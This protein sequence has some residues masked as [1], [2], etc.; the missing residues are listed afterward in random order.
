M[1]AI[2][3]DSG[4]PPKNSKLLKRDFVVD[5]S[6]FVA[7]AS[8]RSESGFEL[9]G[10]CDPERKFQFPYSCTC[11][12]NGRGSDQIC[13]AKAELSVTARNTVH[14]SLRV[15]WP[16]NQT[17]APLGDVLFFPDG[18]KSPESKRVVGKCFIREDGRIQIVPGDDEQRGFPFKVFLVLGHEMKRAIAGDVVADLR[19]LYP[20]PPPP[21]YGT[22]EKVESELYSSPSLDKLLRNEF[23]DRKEYFRDN[24]P[25]PI[26][27]H[28]QIEMFSTTPVHDIDNYYDKGLM[29]Q[30]ET[31]SLSLSSSNV[32]EEPFSVGNTALHDLYDF[33]PHT[34]P[35]MESTGNCWDFTTSTQSTTPNVNDVELS[36]PFDD[37]LNL[38]A[39]P[40]L[41]LDNVSFLLRCYLAVVVVSYHSQLLSVLIT[42]PLLPSSS[43]ISL[44]IF[45]VFRLYLSSPLYSLDL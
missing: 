35:F 8:K 36:F 21:Q 13:A 15:K 41:D 32:F 17:N 11:T 29:E 37:S 18:E 42:A 30:N 3:Q 4:D 22:E 9:V 26:S 10:P 33:S 38:S 45:F 23:D 5:M 2:P 39:Y 1:Y 7:A 31:S 25:S 12:F 16:D 27:A 19:P 24:I 6:Q 40:N 34:L 20:P 28:E 44:Y 43:H 14:P